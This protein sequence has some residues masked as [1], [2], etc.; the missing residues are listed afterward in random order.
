MPLQNSAICRGICGSACVGTVHQ[1][2]AQHNVPELYTTTR[3]E[4]GHEWVK[5]EEFIV[6]PGTP[7]VIKGLEFT[8]PECVMTPVQNRILTQVFFSIEEITENTLNDPDPARVAEYKHM[9]FDVRGYS[10]YAATDNENAALSENCAKAVAF[11]LIRNG[12]PAER[13]RVRAMGSKTSAAHAGSGD[14]AAKLRVEF[15]RT[16]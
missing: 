6:P 16:K 13:L 14:P 4:A 5:T 10:T 8:G 11:N 1:R 3:G 2:T 7:I 9:R 12:T 15:V